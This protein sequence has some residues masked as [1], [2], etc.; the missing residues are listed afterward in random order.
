MNSYKL[1]RATCEALEK[2]NYKF[3]WGDLETHNSVHA[4]SW[5]TIC[6]PKHN[7]GL[8]IRGVREVNKI[9]LVKLAWRTLK[10]PNELWVKV[11]TAKYGNML[12]CLRGESKKAGSVIWR[13]LVV[14]MEVLRVGLR[15]DE[16][17]ITRDNMWWNPSSTRQFTTKS[18]YYMI[19]QPFQTDEVLK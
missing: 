2:A 3:F 16:E 15:H 7:G 13:S 9:L 10:C 4:V 5:E 6:K 18:A 12:S 14:G 19:K 17:E 11:L 1:P 8:N